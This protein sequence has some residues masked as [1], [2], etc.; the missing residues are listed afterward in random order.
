MNWSG[1]WSLQGLV[2]GLQQAVSKVPLGLLECG[3][4]KNKPQRVWIHASNHLAT[5][6]LLTLL[7]IMPQTALQKKQS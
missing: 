5:A 3:S 2:S 4:N 6:V 7:Q 1:Y